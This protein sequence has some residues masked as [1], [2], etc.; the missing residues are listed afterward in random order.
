[1][2]LTS[3]V[4]AAA[5]VAAVSALERS[6]VSLNGLINNKNGQAIIVNRCD[7]DVN[8]WSVYK[9]TGCPLDGMVTLKKGEQYS[10]DFA[11]SKQSNG[12]GVSIK[13]SKTT[14]CKGND[15]T[16]FEYFYD[17]SNINPDYNGNYVDVSYVDCP[18]QD[19]P[20]MKEGYYFRTGDQK[21]AQTQSVNNANTRNPIMS[22]TDPASCAKISYVLPDD[23]QTKYASL[24]QN[25]YYYM[26]GGQ[27]P[28]A[29]DNKPAVSSQKVDTPAPKPTPSKASS[30][31]ENVKVN[32]AA[33][34]PAAEV[35][36]PV[37]VP[38]VK[39]NIVY[40]TKYE[41][42]NA[43]RAEHVHQHARRHQNFHA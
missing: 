43:K 5:M 37:H 4:S 6:A 31:A 8:L 17:D 7:Y 13:I 29:N 38:K 3:V 23:V 15:I 42:V 41:Y 14:Q 1:M 32:A 36:E 9:G 11:D 20:T 33:V 12:V 21:T 40:V 10:E 34:T 24:G 35:K 22:C 28:S 30:A 39:T 2:H 25:V 18:G 27:A 26:C 19:C 16:Q